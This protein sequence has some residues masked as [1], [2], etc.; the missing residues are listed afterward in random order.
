M[1]STKDERAV[2]P[3]SHAWKAS[4]VEDMMGDGKAGLTK[5]VVTGPGQAILFYG[6]W[7]LGEG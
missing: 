3:P 5:A 1:V 7:L 6:Q 4:I 2:P